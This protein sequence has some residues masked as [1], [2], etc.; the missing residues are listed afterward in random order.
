MKIFLFIGGASDGKWIKLKYAS[1]SI[2]MYKEPSP[3]YDMGN[4]DAEEIAQFPVEIYKKVPIT[5]SG[6]GMLGLFDP[7]IPIQHDVYICE[8]MAGVDLIGIL[9][10]GYKPNIGIAVEC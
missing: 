8:S 6:I 10:A 9:L 1:P 7:G 3:V 4:P 2:K 5:S